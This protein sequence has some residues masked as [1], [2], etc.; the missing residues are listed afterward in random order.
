L[1]QAVDVVE[2]FLRALLLAGAAA[3]LV[4]DLAALLALELK[5]HLVDAGVDRIAEIAAGAAERIAVLTTALLLLDLGDVLA[6]SGPTLAH[7][8]GHV[9]HAL[10]QVVECAALGAAG[11]ARVAAAQCLL[12]LA[13]RALGA[14]Q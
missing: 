13:H 4:E 10:L 2:L 5:R 6:V 3:Q 14:A 8:L 7:L 1:Q 9:A 11:L 12:G